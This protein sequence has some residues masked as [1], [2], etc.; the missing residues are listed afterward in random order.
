MVAPLAAI[1]AKLTVPH[2]FSHRWKS[3]RALFTDIRLELW[4]RNDVSK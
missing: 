1:I 2:Y 4:R 3:V